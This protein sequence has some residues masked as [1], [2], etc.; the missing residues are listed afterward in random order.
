MQSENSC[1][2]F[3]VRSY[4]THIVFLTKYLG[5]KRLNQLFSTTLFVIINYLIIY[6]LGI[7]YKV[8]IDELYFIG[9]SALLLIFS[10]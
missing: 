6:W 1:S 4:L 3:S 7:Y 10:L 5:L 8:Q 2:A 9:F